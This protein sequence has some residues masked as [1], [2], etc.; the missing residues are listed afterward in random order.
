MTKRILFVCLGN[1]CRSPMAEEI[2]R[3]KGK[4]SGINIEVDSAGTSGLHAGDPPDARAIVAARIAGYD[5]SDQQARRLKRS[6]FYHFDAIIVMDDRNLQDVLDAQPEDAVARVEM[7]T[8]Y[9]QSLKGQEIPDPYY[10]GKF[11]PAISMIEES[12]DA[13]VDQLRL[14]ADAQ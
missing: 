2:M 9:A 14:G 12:C 6:D 4:S 13:L 5:I 10:S 7:I 3:A 8:S 11:A 1:I